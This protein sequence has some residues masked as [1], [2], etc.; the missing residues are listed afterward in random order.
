MVESILE[1]SPLTD[2]TISSNHWLH[3]HHLRQ[4]AEHQLLHTLCLLTATP[5]LSTESSSF[6]TR[7]CLRSACNNCPQSSQTWLYMAER[8]AHY[9][10]N[11]IQ[12]A[13]ALEIT[14]A[15]KQ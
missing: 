1:G 12:M 4:Q 7:T 6:A 11:C 13:T 5:D 3:H 2:L 10:A 14:S 9:M 8:N 15:V